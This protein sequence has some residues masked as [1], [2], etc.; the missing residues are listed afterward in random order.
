LYFQVSALGAESKRLEDIHPDHAEA[1][2]SKQTE[3]EDNWTRLKDK[4]CE[5][6]ILASFLSH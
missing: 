5:S 1:I 2:N 4:V 3:I 6:H